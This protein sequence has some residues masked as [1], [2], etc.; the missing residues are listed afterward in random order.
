MEKL[1][2]EELQ[3]IATCFDCAVKHSENSLQASQQL[4]PLLD[5][6]EGMAENGDADGSNSSSN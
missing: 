1:T 4:L 3:I 6:L 2:Q 5:K